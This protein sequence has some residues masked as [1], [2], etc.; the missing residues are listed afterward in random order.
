VNSAPWWLA[1]ATAALSGFLAITASLLTTR[2][3]SKH[4]RERLAQELG[5]Q[6]ELE[7]KKLLHDRRFEL[8]QE[9]AG[10]SRGFEEIMAN[11]STLDTEP[12][13]NSLSEQSG[14][15]ESAYGRLVLIGSSSVI[16]EY[17]HV[18]LTV[19]KVI[20]QIAARAKSVKLVDSYMKFDNANRSLIRHMRIDLDA[21]EPLPPALQ[22]RSKQLLEFS[23]FVDPASD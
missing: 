9:I 23:L 21:T 8:Y 11:G 1:V 14:R 15:L 18:L 5:H 12:F 10:N 16:T 22:Q 4:A 13:V 6:R 2:Q 7:R 19:N 20:D 17:V 3:A